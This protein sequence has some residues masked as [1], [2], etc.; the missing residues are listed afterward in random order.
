MNLHL[1]FIRF[2]YT[3]SPPRAQPPN[4]F[5]HKL[6]HFSTLLR[7]ARKKKAPVGEM[8]GSQDAATTG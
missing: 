7:A 5:C 6:L 3:Q 2:H 1:I 8:R 4:A